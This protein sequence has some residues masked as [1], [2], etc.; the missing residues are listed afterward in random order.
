[1]G[2]R[3]ICLWFGIFPMEEIDGEQLV[4]SI[5]KMLLS[6]RGQVLPSFLLVTEV[7]GRG[8]H[9]YHCWP[10]HSIILNFGASEESGINIS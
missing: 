6:H 8:K 7:W 1:M 3:E 5:Y 4:Y 9:K 10:L 2:A